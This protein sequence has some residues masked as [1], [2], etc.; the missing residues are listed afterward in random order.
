MALS[1]G[2]LAYW[3][4]RTG[5]PTLSAELAERYRA[6]AGREF[7]PFQAPAR[8]PAGSYDV[9][10]DAQERA[11][12]RGYGDLQED[13]DIGRTRGE[14]D[15][16]L[17]TGDIIRGRDR[18]LADL[19]RDASRFREDVG[20]RRGGLERDFTRSNDDIVRQYHEL[21]GAQTQAGTAAGLAGG[22]FAQAAAARGANRGRA[23][24]R[25]SE[26]VQA[27]RDELTRQ[28]SRFDEDYGV[29]TGRINEDAQH[30]VSRLGLGFERLFGT[31]G[32][33]TRQ[34]TRG[35][36]ELA[37]GRQDISE[38][39]FG[40]ASQAGYEVPTRPENESTI[41]GVT[42]RRLGGGRYQ[43]PDGRIVNRQGLRALYQ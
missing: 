16:A 29:Q 32:D 27:A 28:S 38:A 33:M 5:R 35:G 8:P 10:L 17:G 40:Q 26:D 30:G 39:R 7:T 11:I 2:Q 6:R 12:E 42:F 24:T 21:G 34:L 36:R 1:A 3:R 13:F 41:R 4:Q 18:S 37:A 22:Y 43:L 23:Q 31:Q 19:V 20:V 15:L 9:G 14:T 25:L